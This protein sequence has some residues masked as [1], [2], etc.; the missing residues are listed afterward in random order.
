MPRFTVGTLHE[1]LAWFR[2]PTDQLRA[3]VENATG[4]IAAVSIVGGVWHLWTR[5]L[6]HRGDSPVC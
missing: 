2:R 6:V 5:G 4:G 3:I 1:R